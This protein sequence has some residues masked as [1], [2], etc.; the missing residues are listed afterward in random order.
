MNQNK[1]YLTDIETCF[2][3]EVSKERY[4]NH[5][6]MWELVVPKLNDNTSVSIL[7]GTTG[8]I[9]SNNLKELFINGK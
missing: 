8:E 7:Y 9:E 5:V 6:K 1:Y 2:K 3:Y 4:E